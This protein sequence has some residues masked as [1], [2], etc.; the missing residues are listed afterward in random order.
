MYT[1]K[2]HTPQKA[3]RLFGDPVFKRY[4]LKRSQDTHIKAALYAAILVMLMLSV[5]FVMRAVV[6][7][8]ADNILAYDGGRPDAS[9]SDDVY[10][11][12]DAIKF[13]LSQEMPIIYGVD[14]E[15]T[16]PVEP[17]HGLVNTEI[18]FNIA[19]DEIRMEIIKYS[20]EPKSFY[21]GAGGPHI[22]IYHTHL[23]EAYRQILGGEY[24][25]AGKWYTKDQLNSVAAVGDALKAALEGYGYSVLHDVTDHMSEGL[26]SAYSKSLETMK[27]YAVQYPGLKVY[28]DVHRDSGK[29]EKDYVTINGEECARV[30]FVVGTGKGYT[31]VG[32]DGKPY[33]ESNYKLALAVT[34]ELENIKEG[35]TRPIRVK[36][37]RYNQQVSDMCLL[38]EVGHNANSLQQAI[39]STKYVAQA[40]SRVIEISGP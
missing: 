14:V 23:E 16:E 36:T 12:I 1:Y 27:K 29:N 2:R 17:Q 20:K 30:M 21:V 11:N 7:N 33:F 10:A 15:K 5:I 37:G 19:T 18:D 9:G 35:F 22:L 13:I 34:N 26:K 38:I 24:V 6:S 3:S 32:F 28:I 8:K 39:N 25:E 40:I 31:G 4:P